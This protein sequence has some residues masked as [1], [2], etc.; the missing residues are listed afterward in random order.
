[1]NSQEASDVSPFTTWLPAR[2]DQ[3][4]DL[5]IEVVGRGV[6]GLAAEIG[7]FA[8]ALTAQGLEV[9]THTRQLNGTAGPSVLR[10]RV[11]SRRIHSAGHGCDVLV[12]L[13][14]R[15]PDFDA[16][17]LQR[18]SILL[19]EPSENHRVELPEGII[20]YPVPCWQL[21]ALFGGGYAGAA[22]A[23]LGALSHLLGMSI[24]T[25][26]EARCSPLD[27]RPFDAGLEFA[28]RYIV[29][30]DLY[31]LPAVQVAKAPLLLGMQQAIKLGLALGYCECGTACRPT[32]DSAPVEWLTEHLAAADHIVSLLQSDQHPSVH[33][34]RGPD[35][36][37]L[38]LQGGDDQTLSS[39]LGNRA[40][41]TILV[42]S[43]VAGLLQLLST[44]HRAPHHDEAG[45]VGILVEDHLGAS[46]QSL[47]LDTVA[48]LLSAEEPPSSI[49]GDQGPASVS[50]HR[51]VKIDA[52]PGA[53]VGYVAWGTAQGVVRDAVELSRNFGL[54]VSALY[55]AV[56]QPF[57]MAQLESFAR[58][59]DRVVVVESDHAC[60]HAQ[61]VGRLCSFRPSVVMP[62]PDKPL[63]PMDLFLRE[64]LGA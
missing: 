11:A 45:V 35:G 60:L 46:W 16:F 6:P 55:P 4:C 2:S 30:H 10:L 7:T 40:A 36:R 3:Y 63:T 41:Q 22:L 53:S 23:A 38:V 20:M 1:M 51:W 54:R 21:S 32:L 43:D 58:T 17:G 27:M 42:A 8:R 44:G 37:L 19:C 59:V 25:M 9:L 29:K 61:R 50:R 34:Y 15:T 62:E 26:R 47:A 56:I 52:E 64:G 18:G 31:A 5:V 33:A 48:D 24:E 39:C 13:D 12:Y 28:R 49:P 14:D 57:P